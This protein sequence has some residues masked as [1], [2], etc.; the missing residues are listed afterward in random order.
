MSRTS[1]RSLARAALLT[2]AGAASV[3]G[4]AGA[5]SALDAEAATHA[6]GG[7]NQLDG[8]GLGETVDTTTRHAAGF[9]GE[10]GGETVKQALPV[11]GEAAGSTAKSVLPKTKGLDQTRS[12]L[13]DTTSSLTDQLGG[14]DAGDTLG[15]AA[16]GNQLGTPSKLLGGLPLS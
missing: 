10:K 9:A 7:V 15:N 5:A 4:S 1:T 8:G 16:N 13:G 2:A 14:V 3:V 6:L 11:V 12:A